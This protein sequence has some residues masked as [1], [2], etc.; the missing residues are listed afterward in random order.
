M[1]LV[2]PQPLDQRPSDSANFYDVRRQNYVYTCEYLM[3]CAIHAYLEVVG[4]ALSTSDLSKG[5]QHLVAYTQN[6]RG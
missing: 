5:M 4:L 3:R 2:L 6:S 1:T